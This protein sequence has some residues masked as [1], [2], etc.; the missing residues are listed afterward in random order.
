M[1]HDGKI[2]LQNNI[3]LN[4][5]HHYQENHNRKLRKRMNI[6]ESYIKLTQTVAVDLKMITHCNKMTNKKIQ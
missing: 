3:I 2:S 4:K 1:L 5:I 6:Q